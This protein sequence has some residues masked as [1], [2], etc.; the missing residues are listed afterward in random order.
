VK[1]EAAGSGVATPE[2][3][4]QIKCGR[5]GAETQRNA[6]HG[7]QHSISVVTALL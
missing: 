1:T 4:L 3:F 2:L 5:R 6:R 7:E